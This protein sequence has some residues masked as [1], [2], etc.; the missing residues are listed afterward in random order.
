MAYKNKVL[1]NSKGYMFKAGFQ[2]NVAG[3]ANRVITNQF[4]D[5]LNCSKTD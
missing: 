3:W 1:R 5:K 4:A 2:F